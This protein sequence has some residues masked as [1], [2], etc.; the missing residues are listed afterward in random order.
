MP[1][2]LSLLLAPLILGA[3]PLVL[4]AQDISY[5]TTTRA[6][7]GGALGRIMR[8]VPG[9]TDPTEETTSIHGRL[10]R[11]DHDESSTLME[12]ES[13][14]FTFLDH[15][16]ATYW[17]MEWGDAATMWEQSAAAN[18]PEPERS[19]YVDE[20]NR[21]TITYETSFDVER[22][23]DRERINGYMAERVFFTLMIDATEEYAGN[24]DSVV[25]GTMVLLTEMWISDEFPAYEALKEM[26]PGAQVN[27]NANP[28][29]LQFDPRIGTALERLQ[30]E[31]EGLEG[32]SMKTV[33]H[34][35]VV[36]MEL[37]FD[38]DAVLRD[39][40]RSLMADVA[41]AAVPG[42]TN[43]ARRG[44]RGLT[45]GLFGRRSEPER[46]APKQAVIMRVT[47]EIHDVSEAPL[48]PGIF[49]RPENYQPRD[50]F[51]GMDATK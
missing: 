3:T 26:R 7:F 44:L 37:D 28:M 27:T 14:S 33:A 39:A 13:L 49:V 34:F 38:R 47:T 12:L 24:P 10:M 32:L 35:V 51:A 48:D 18:M 40:D 9:G 45:G 50:R 20:E 46:P 6:E 31:M 8:L 36:P 25:G 41:D 2:P 21:R 11:V 43:A 1:K 19:V 15:S 16:S 29:A 23:G 17:T 5:T 4:A 30:E 42:V 22:T